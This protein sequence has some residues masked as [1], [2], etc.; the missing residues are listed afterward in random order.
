MPLVPALRQAIRDVD[1]RLPML[2]VASLKSIVSDATAQERFTLRLLLVSAAT[3]LFLGVVGVYGVLAYSVRRR[4]AEIGVRLA[5]G[6]SPARVTRL[7]VSQGAMLSMVGIVI[8]LIASL[9]LT[10][11]I[12]S[13]L[14]ETSPTD[15]VTFAGVT[16]MLF[17]VAL[18]ASY[19][20]AR[21][22]SRVDPARAIRAD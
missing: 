18:A 19:L 15:P 1:P 6:A 11:F 7:I 3:A 22:A 4:T 21:R 12:E 5:L 13:L 10:G 8:G 17:G 2:D 9:L 16:L 20:P 14:Y